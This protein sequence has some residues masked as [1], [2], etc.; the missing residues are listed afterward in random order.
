MD[1]WTKDRFSQQRL[2]IEDFLKWRLKIQ[3]I[4]FKMA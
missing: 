4:S 2:L 1:I 3:D